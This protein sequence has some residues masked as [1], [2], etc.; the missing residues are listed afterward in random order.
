[1]LARRTILLLCI[2]ML[3]F[4]ACKRR[5]KAEDAPPEQPAV[6]LSSFRINDPAAVA[7]LTHGF[8]V[9]EQDAWRWVAGKFGV[10]LAAP[11][12]AERGARLALRFSLP[13]VV[14]QK[15]GPVTI[16]AQIA[17]VQ[18]APQR[19]DSTGEHVY[20]ADFKAPLS[21]PVAVEFSTDK[22]LAAGSVDARELSIIVLEVGLTAYPA[23]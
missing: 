17:G 15:L 12:G 1:M 2:C 5:P 7:Q 14:L 23:Q 16:S 4:A 19:F 18:L 9:L 8:Y 21:G 13:D 20:L 6:L 22:S 10:A 3:F 11:A